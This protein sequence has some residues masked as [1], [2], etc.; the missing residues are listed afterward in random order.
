[1][2]KVRKERSEEFQSSVLVGFGKPGGIRRG[3]ELKYMRE[4]KGNK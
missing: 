4:E 1:M 2:G 3:V